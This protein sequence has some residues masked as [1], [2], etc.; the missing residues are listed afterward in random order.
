ML[1]SPPIAV[2]SR[3]ARIEARSGRTRSGSTVVSLPCS[4]G[5][6]TCGRDP[7]VRRIALRQRFVPSLCLVLEPFTSSRQSRAHAAWGTTGSRTTSD[8]A[9]KTGTPDAVW[10]R[11]TGIMLAGLLQRQSVVAAAKCK[12]ED[13]EN[14]HASTASQ[15]ETISDDDYWSF[16]GAARSPGSFPGPARNDR[17]C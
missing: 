8:V 5:A 2:S 7:Q 6:P 3:Q 10:V 9:Q 1:P 13:N 17:R 15:S 16:I 11:G 4:C 12:D 14:L